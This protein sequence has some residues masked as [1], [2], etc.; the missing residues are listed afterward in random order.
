MAATQAQA[1]LDAYVIIVNISMLLSFLSSHTIFRLSR[2]KK[3]LFALIEQYGPAYKVFVTDMGLLEELRHEEEMKHNTYDP[4]II[5]CTDF[6][7]YIPPMSLRKEL[8]AYSSISL[9]RSGPIIPLSRRRI[10]RGGRIIYD[11][12]RKYPTSPNYVN[13]ADVVMNTDRLLWLSKKKTVPTY[14]S[15][16]ESSSSNS[17]MAQSGDIPAFLNTISYRPNFHLHAPGSSYYSLTNR[18][19]YSTPRWT[20]DATTY[21]PKRPRGPRLPKNVLPVSAVESPH[22]NSTIP[23]LGRPTSVTM[24]KHATHPSTTTI[25]ANRPMAVARNYPPSTPV[26]ARDASPVSTTTTTMITPPQ[27]S[28]S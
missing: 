3:R 12:L 4:E 25:M 13:P 19:S 21:I 20:N 7:T 26:A 27:T 2:E 28:A 17:R 16:T 11:R 6:D 5:D 14:F 18:Y 15:I 8:L 22:D 24:Y 1:L 23:P 9:S 10:G